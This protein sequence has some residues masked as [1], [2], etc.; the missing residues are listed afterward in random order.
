M[1][2]D[3]VNGDYTLQGTSP[4]IDGGD[5]QYVTLNEDLLGNARIYGSAVDMGAYEFGSSLSIADAEGNIT[6]V[7]LYPNPASNIINIISNQVNI[8]SV[9]I[10]D[11][12]GKQVL[13]TTN[14]KDINVSDLRSGMY[15]V[16]IEFEN[17]TSASKRFI[18]L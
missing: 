3:S 14:K 12:L 10:Y 1:F 7:K 6:E 8:K 4:A 17:N 15:I 5:N 11:V 9:G 18:K 13:A 16:K 2:T